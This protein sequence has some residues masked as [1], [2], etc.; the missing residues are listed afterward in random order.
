MNKSE[1]FHKPSVRE[2]TKG[3][4]PI[5]ASSNLL[6]IVESIDNNHFLRIK[7]DLHPFET[8]KKFLRHGKELRII[9]PPTIGEH[10]QRRKTPVEY[11]L[12]SMDKIK[13][14]YYA[15]Y[16]FYPL[17]EGN[18]RKI[19]LVSCVDGAK[20]YYYVYHFSTGIEILDFDD[21]QRVNKDGA[22]IKVRVPSR[23]PKK[24]AYL[25]KFTSFPVADDFNKYAVAYSLNTEGHNCEDKLHTNI[26]YKFQ[27]AREHSKF[28]SFCDH[29]I[30]AYLWLIDYFH[31]EKHNLIPWQMSHF[32]IPTN[33]IIELD[34]TLQNKVVIERLDKSN[35]PKD[36]A[37]TEQD[38]EVF[39]WAAVKKYDPQKTFFRRNTIDGLLKDAP[40]LD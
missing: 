21:A 14:P 12:E 39:F 37:L 17:R 20:L 26:S 5:E 6:S 35:E 36:Y 29:E 2:I 32:A 22:E 4:T 34:K 8:P 10:I 38:R 28:V 9:M 33:R 30:A 7:R 18:K 3:K 1:F 11:R 19:S 40:Y 25:F 24:K 16:S 31:N 23:T 13:D 15:C 27:G